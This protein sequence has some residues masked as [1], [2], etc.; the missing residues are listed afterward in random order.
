MISECV[1]QILY[2][3]SKTVST[4]MKG[5][6]GLLQLSSSDS[7][8]L[9]SDSDF[10]PSSSLPKRSSK[11]KMPS[12]PS[13]SRS[14]Q[15]TGS[16]RKRSKPVSEVSDRPARTKTKPSKL[17]SSDEA[18]KPNTS[19]NKH[20][21]QKCHLLDNS[22]KFKS[23]KS[24]L[25]KLSSDSDA[26]LP[27][28]KL[29]KLC[30]PTPSSSPSN[31]SH[32]RTKQCS[33]VL[34]KLKVKKLLS[35]SS[36]L[37]N[38]S[39]SD[40]SPQTKDKNISDSDPSP[41]TKD[42]NISDSD[43]SPQTKDKNIS[44]IH[45]KGDKGVR[46]TRL[47]KRTRDYS[48]TDQF[49]LKRTAPPVLPNVQGVAGHVEG[50]PGNVSPQLSLLA[51]GLSASLVVVP[52]IEVEKVVP[53]SSGE[54]EIEDEP[55]ASSSTLEAEQGDEVVEGDHPVNNQVCQLYNFKT[56]EMFLQL[57]LNFQ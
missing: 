12:K 52:V 22:D 28:M 46:Y 49:L 48:T 17:Y 39:D 35:V 23:N 15:R 2:K 11:R 40:P 25:Q 44:D 6:S 8:C 21:V 42:K 19:R 26:S 3:L 45:N 14:S 1:I 10:K 36:Q 31:L 30:K 33:I 34:E 57:V 32:L 51:N 16:Q 4:A 50:G 54:G 20:K 18:G 37:H 29:S 47:N 7:D 56:K 41:Q 38:I 53:V 43:P 27:D 55:A 13:S 9:S 24:R 5:K